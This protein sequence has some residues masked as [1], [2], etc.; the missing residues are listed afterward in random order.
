MATVMI[1][2]ASRGIGLELVKQYLTAGDTVIGCVRDT[3]AAPQLDEVAAGQG[4]LRIEALDIGDP[5]SIDAA[6][7]SIG[8]APLDVVV[9]CAG[10]VG[11]AEQALDNVNIEEWHKTL[12]I[13][14]IGPTLV[15]RAFKSNLAASGNG[16]LMILSSQLAAST[17]PMGGML[18]YSTTKA[19]VSK[20]GQILA[21]DWKDEPITVTVN[22]PGWVQTDMGGPHAEITA[23]DSAKGIR[24]VIAGASKDD[25]GKFFKWN[26]EIHP[27]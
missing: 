18:I 10:Y 1:V 9:V 21:I 15:A 2:G 25:S 13:N 19:A 12:D 23:E 4:D 20:V 24:E 22:H 16:H 14:T 7:A 27:W 11:G 8:D 17:W 5:A 6:A 3:A 26:G